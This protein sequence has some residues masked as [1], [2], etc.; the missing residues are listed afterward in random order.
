MLGTTG[1][2]PLALNDPSLLHNSPL[3]NQWM[4]RL[5]E[6]AARGETSL[7]PLLDR[8]PVALELLAA[9]AATWERHSHRTDSALRTFISQVQSSCLPSS[10]EAVS[11]WIQS[12][13]DC[14]SRYLRTPNNA[15]HQSHITIKC[16]AA[17]SQIWDAEELNSS[18]LFV[19]LVTWLQ[20]DRQPDEIVSRGRF[21]AQ[22]A[23][24]ATCGRLCPG[25]NS[26]DWLVK[27]KQQYE[28]WASAPADKQKGFVRPAI[29]HWTQPISLD[30]VLSELNG[31]M[32]EPGLESVESAQ[33]RLFFFLTLQNDPRDCEGLRLLDQLKVLE[34]S[35]RYQIGLGRR[36]SSWQA[37]WEVSDG[38]EVVAR[39]VPGHF[40]P[41]DLTLARAA[42]GILGLAN[43]VVPNYPTL[44]NGLRPADDGDAV[45]ALRTGQV[46][47]WNRDHK[48]RLPWVVG[49][50][51]P[52]MGSVTLEG[53]KGCF[54][55]CDPRVGW[56][57]ANAILGIR[58]CDSDRPGVSFSRDGQ[59]VTTDL[60]S[61]MS[62]TFGSTVHLVD[63]EP[64]KLEWLPEEKR[65]GL[66][67]LVVQ[68]PSNG[69]L[70]GTREAAQT[71][72]G[73]LEPPLDQEWK[74]LTASTQA[75]WT[76]EEVKC[77]R[78]RA[79]AAWQAKAPFPTATV[80]NDPRTVSSFIEHFN[81]LMRGEEMGTSEEASQDPL[82]TP[83]GDLPTP[84]DE[85]PTS[86]DERVVKGSPMHGGAMEILSWF[87]RP[88]DLDLESSEGQNTQTRRVFRVLSFQPVSDSAAL[89]AH[90]SS[91]DTGLVK[92]TSSNLLGM[93]MI[94]LSG[95]RL[96]SGSHQEPLSEE[97]AR[98]SQLEPSLLGRTEASSSSASADRK[99]PLQSPE[100]SPWRVI[101]I[102]RGQPGPLNVRIHAQPTGAGTPVKK[103]KRPVRLRLD[104]D[105]ASK[106]P[107]L[108]SP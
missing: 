100:R 62:Q 76:A 33:R 44:F 104:F 31:W 20:G 8:C 41:G 6:V 75:R 90:A 82:S 11:G 46:H 80:V 9:L 21:F 92:S 74:D 19:A 95:R 26:R 61:V 1:R 10:D 69:F 85:R 59:L 101:H 18:S 35:G 65:G 50:F 53:E 98:K 58:H 94:I 52:A 13:G 14:Y 89:A 70:T 34:L 23:L 63:F 73:M 83:W 93:G 43:T 38:R 45:S 5:E 16:P 3:A 56:V 51:Q 17:N 37:V 66:Q 107:S 99:T 68:I 105:Q 55:G 28:Q 32:R 4:D 54:K 103:M 40:L 71:L 7:D 97:I 29:E 106:S 27:W 60:L 86:A 22:T 57:V 67:E 47:L 49:S 12:W 24:S 15:A 79:S 36:D 64:M 48:G 25:R 42:L 72:T 96:S 81:R 78:A 91:Q 88:G 30:E 2:S 102:V 77:F 39:F 108:E 87:G 84:T